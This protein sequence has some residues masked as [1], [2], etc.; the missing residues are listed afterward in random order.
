VARIA[1]DIDSTL[2][3]FE[4]PFRQ[5]CLDLAF[6]RDDKEKY[7]KAAYHSWVQW[8]SPADLDET[9]F[10]E[11]LAR[12]HS[13]AVILSRTPFE[14]AVDVVSK[15]AEEHEVFYITNRDPDC[16]AATHAWLV[17]HGFPNASMLICTMD[18][19]AL[20]L[21]DCQY[22]IDD[23]P[24]T[25]VEFV[26]DRMWSTYDPCKGECSEDKERKAFSL[27]FEYNDSLTDIPNVYLAP[28]WAGIEY[29]LTE[30]GVLN[31]RSVSA[32]L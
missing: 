23:R 4:T 19:K 7:F 30:K 24:K 10:A 16:H 11:A 31:G 22:I 9:I 1:I 15:L 25:M 12:V 17:K 27:M 6:E 3:D 2:Y 5:A 13:D 32:A 14:N 21:K 26:Y 20:H 29:Y 18:N 28:T 8:R